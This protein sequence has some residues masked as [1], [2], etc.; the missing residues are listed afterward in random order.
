MIAVLNTLRNSPQQSEAF[1]KTLEEFTGVNV[2]SIPGSD[3]IEDGI[4]ASIPSCRPNREHYHM[5][6]QAWN[7]FSPPSAKR[8]QALL[9]YMEIQAGML[10]QIDSC[11]MV[12]K[13]WAKKC[14]AEG[15]QAF[16]D[17]MTKV[18]GVKPDLI[19]FLHVLEAWSKS[20]SP[21]AAK[22]ADAL[23]SLMG[24]MKI[25]PNAECLFRVIECWAKSTRKGAEARIE[26]LLAW[27]KRRIKEDPEQCDQ[28]VVQ[29]AMWNVL[30][31]YQTVRNAHRAEEILLD[32][33][34]EYRTSNV[35]IPPTVEMCL[36]VLNTW[37]KSNSTRRAYRAEKLLSLM[38]KDRSFPKPN[39]ECYNSVLN[40]FA[41]TRRRGSGSRAEALLRRMEKSKDVAPN[42]MSMTCVLI[43]WAHS[44]NVH[45]ASMHAERLFRE[46][47][48]RG[49]EPDRFVFAGLITAWGRNPSEDSIVKV[50]EYF[51]RVKDMQRSG[52]S[53][54]HVAA[55]RRKSFQPTTVEYNATINA[56]AN[57]VTKNV[58]GSRVAVARVETLLDEMLD[59]ED[60]SLKPNILTYAAALKTIAGARRIPDRGKHA[61]FILRIM[62]NEKLEISPYII[63]LVKKC[64]IR[65]PKQNT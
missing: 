56:Y 61:D 62:E 46:I 54:G 65:E 17:K 7:D 34:G 44:D 52:Q 59:S 60:E 48:D 14:N 35:T 25:Q 64:N 41:G 49:M 53:H 47:Q 57:W 19:S 4:A 36:S 29:A 16:F 3:T 55:S 40:C 38:E 9:D 58:G 39:V 22:R 20:K 27:M 13:T 30:Q 15:A 12:L 24:E 11:N 5:V 2:A 1:V 28:H 21:L 33:V 32:F 51:E 23:L 8:A 6:L 45:E 63:G 26:S 10:Y 42:L 31:A 37:S 18:R 43:T 50:E